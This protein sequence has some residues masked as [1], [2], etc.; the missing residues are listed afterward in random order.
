MLTVSGRASRAFAP[1]LRPL[2]HPRRPASTNRSPSS[3][4][5][6]PYAFTVT[7]GKAVSKQKAVE[8]TRAALHR[9]RERW[10]SRSHK[11]PH[12]AVILASKNLVS[13]LEDE[14]FISGILE[15]FRLGAV[16]SG[17]APV[18]H[19]LHAAMDRVPTLRR[20]PELHGQISVLL[21][22][23][24]DLVPG[25]WTASGKLEAES[26]ML[27]SL[28]LSGLPLDP[29]TS[30]LDVTVPLANTSFNNGRTYTM[31]ACE[32]ESGS[33]DQLRLARRLEKKTQTVV[34]GKQQG[35]RR[36]SIHTS[37]VPITQPRKIVAGLGNIIRLL[38]GDSPS[39]KPLPASK[40]LEEVIPKMLEQRKALEQAPQAGP[41]GVWALV[42]PEH[43]TLKG[44]VSASEEDG[45]FIHKVLAAGGRLCRILSGGGGWGAKQGLLSLDPQTRY[46]SPD[47]EDVESFIRSFRGDTSDDDGSIIRPGSSIQFY[48]EPPR[49][50]S[51]GEPGSVA[52][53]SSSTLSLYVGTQDEAET[54]FGS[55]ENPDA[56]SVTV[57][58]FGAISSQGIYL[59]SAANGTGRSSDAP[60]VGTKIDAPGSAI[61]SAERD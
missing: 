47:Q 6:G 41:M 35:I 61:F 38:E 10:Q 21:G 57:N 48:V 22:T 52:E 8:A 30:Q 15:P 59:A 29:P 58:L 46:T 56:V 54:P 34:I 2:L 32:W 33:S 16:G 7:L 23:T 37:L 1:A 24:S 17:A 13:W 19:T 28:V 27:P 5:N 45:E 40:E 14:R 39:L 12:A 36:S 25:L 11:D 51:K 4:E 26:S 42:V 18:L 9:F 43:F 53:V 49:N 20:S 55:E 60:T 50:L 44:D 3:G 31:F